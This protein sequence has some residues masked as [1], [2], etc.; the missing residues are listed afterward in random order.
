MEVAVGPRHFDFPISQSA[1]ARC[2]RGQVGTQHTGVRHEDDVGTQQ[3]AVFPAEGFEAGGAY[4]FLAF[5]DELHVV[6]QQTVADE[7]FEG[8]HLDER[9]ALV[10]VGAACPDAPV[11]QLGFEG[12][13]F[14]QF[15]RFGRHHVVMGVDEDGLCFGVHNLLGE[16]HRVSLRGHHQGF[17]CTGLEQQLTPAFGAG[18][19]VVVVFG[20]GAD[21]GNA[22][23]AEQF[24]QHA[25]LVFGDIS[26]D[27]KRKRNMNERLYIIYRI[28]S[29]PCS[30]F[31][32]WK[33]EKERLAYSC[34]V[35]SIR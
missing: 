30:S 6:R 21:A 9:L 22:D 5:E 31:L 12:V 4:F 13:A 32:L 19:H 7:V 18:Q 11:A 34:V 24:V 16:H 17:V 33:E 25:G 35:R 27:H 3:F 14:P 20:F 23:E 29:L 28:K 10:I 8:F 26:L 1:Q 15:Q 2:Q